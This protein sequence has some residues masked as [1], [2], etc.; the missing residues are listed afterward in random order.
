MN[1]SKTMLLGFSVAI[2]LVATVAAARDSFV[3]IG[4]KQVYKTVFYADRGDSIQIIVNAQVQVACVLFDKDHD[5]LE[6]DTGRTACVLM[7]EAPYTGKYSLEILNKADKEARVVI[8]S[9]NL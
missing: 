8:S 9:N 6:G 3:T 5:D 7:R 2:M 1:R 4:G